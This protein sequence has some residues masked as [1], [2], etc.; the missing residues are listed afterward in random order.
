MSVTDFY[1]ELIIFQRKRPSVV[2]LGVIADPQQRG[3]LSPQ[4]LSSHKKPS[5]DS[6]IHNLFVTLLVE[7]IICYQNSPSH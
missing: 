3:G 7:L 5:T 1:D 4:E 2:Y 6:I